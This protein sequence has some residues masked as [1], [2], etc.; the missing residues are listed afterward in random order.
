MYSLFTFY[1]YENPF[2]DTWPTLET[3][4]LGFLMVHVYQS[5]VLLWSKIY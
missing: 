3:F 5:F 1:G 4:L 2:D